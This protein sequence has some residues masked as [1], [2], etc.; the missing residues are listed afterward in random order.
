MAIQTE[1]FILNV[2]PQHPS[3]HGVF[4]MKVTLD[5]EVVVDVEPVI[6]YLHRGIEKMGE[7]RTYTQIIPLTDR[8]DYLASLTNNLAYV[9]AVEKQARTVE[10]EVD[11]HTPGD[12]A[13]LLVGYSADIEIVI[14]GRDGAVRIPTPAL[15]PGNRVLVLGDDGVLQERRIDTGLSN[16]E[17]T[18]VKTGLSRDE[19]VVTSL[20]REGVKAG[21]RAM[22]E[23]KEAA[24]SP[25]E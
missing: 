25:V 11:F 20:E 18:E 1:P 23:Q 7:N 19:R 10:V 14:T 12:A 9:L 5:G 24:K 4:R 13:H 6:G 21:A 3:T 16:W 2:G 17:F 8:L 15:M 22:A